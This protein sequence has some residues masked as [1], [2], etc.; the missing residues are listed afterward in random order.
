M[1]ANVVWNRTGNYFWNSILLHGVG[2]GFPREELQAGGLGEL[3]GCADRAVL[4]GFPAVATCSSKRAC[5]DPE[6]LA[7]TCDAQ[8]N[9]DAL[10]SVPHI[11][12]HPEGVYSCQTNSEHKPIRLFNINKSRHSF[13]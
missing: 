7:V 3:W 12:R 11:E 8:R 9:G 13:P 1:S 10:Q 4:G 2:G 5:V 6:D